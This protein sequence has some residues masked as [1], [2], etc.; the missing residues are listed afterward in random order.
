MT[1]YLRNCWYMAAWADE[2]A[3]SGLAR[4]LLEQ[5]IFLFRNGEGIVK[6]LFDRCPHRFAPLSMGHVTDGVVTCRYHGLA[7]DASGTCV[8]NPHGPISRA[9]AT[10]SFP[11]V[12]AHRAIWIWMGD[13]EKADAA[14]IR[15]LAFLGSAPDTAFNKGYVLG[16]GNYQLFVDNILD[17]SHTDYLHPDTLGGGSI[18][19]TRAHVE[20]RDD[21][22][23]AI[24]WDSYDDVPPPLVRQK[25]PAG[26][27]R[28][29]SWT[30][31]EWSAPGIMKL[32]NGAVPTG[33]P[34]EG[35]GNSINVHIMTPETA[36]TTHYFFA[37]TRDYALDDAEM[38]A[39]IGRIRAQIF[40][41]EDEP[42]I[43]A[44]QARMGDQGF[45]DLKPALLRID[46]GAVAVRRRLDA[47]IAAE[48]GEME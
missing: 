21:G 20:Q 37:S 18:T 27:E 40:S 43:A 4:T 48:Q 31:V 13:P 38:N 47:M 7:F 45:W 24:Q 14:Q 10:R 5:P 30:H 1:H 16:G 12:E 11:V 36:T 9:L 29:D 8:H 32:V 28:A 15:D 44:Q 33:S 3:E 46:E 35:A 25:M 42:M 26:V 34:R 41:T 22:I 2:V 19:R 39:A 23:I 17:L 6:A